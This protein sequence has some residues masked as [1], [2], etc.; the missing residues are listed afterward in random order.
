MVHQRR[1]FHGHLQPSLLVG[2]H[3]NMTKL[4]KLMRNK[5]KLIDTSYPEGR[6]LFIWTTYGMWLL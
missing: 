2:P 3:K 5:F 6:F 1:V 4:C